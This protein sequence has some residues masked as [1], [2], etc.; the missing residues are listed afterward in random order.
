M[1]VLEFAKKICLYVSLLRNPVGYI[2]QVHYFSNV[3]AKIYLVLGLWHLKYFTSMAS[4]DQHHIKHSVNTLGEKKS[5]ILLECV[6]Y[7]LQHVS[8]HLPINLLSKVY[9]ESRTQKSKTRTEIYQGVGIIQ[10]REICQRFW[11]QIF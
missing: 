8:V 9:T 10:G 5:L 6:E 1:L 3:I 11:V 4:L 2:F 7:L